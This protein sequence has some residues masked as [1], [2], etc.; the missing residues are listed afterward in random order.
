MVEDAFT[1]E[2]YAKEWLSFAE[3]DLASAEFLLSMRPLPVTIVNAKAV[4]DFTQPL[5]NQKS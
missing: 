4:C 3:M 5:I 2:S 1:P